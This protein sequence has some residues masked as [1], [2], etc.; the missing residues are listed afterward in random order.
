M[1]TTRWTTLLS[2]LVVAIPM[3]AGAAPQSI[4]TSVA[5]VNLLEL[6]T[7]EGCSSCPPADAWLSGLMNDQRLW[8]QI[9]PVAF[10]VDYWDNLGWHDPFD[11]HLYSERQQHIA[12]RAGDGVIYTPEFVLDGKPWSNWFNLRSLRLHDATAGGRLKLVVDGGRL[13]ASFTPV[14]TDQKYLELHVAILAFGVNTK[15]SAGENAGRTLL[16]DFLVIGY[17]KQLL[18]KG[19]SGFSSVAQLPHSI[20]VQASRYALA[21]WI[22]QP[23]DPA[24]LQSAGGWLNKA[25]P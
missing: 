24:P 20:K 10:H 9:V 19:I 23:G 3:M 11:K 14:N 5:R 21:V 16:Q 22:S 13:T 8:K 18:T 15:V 12:D 17:A 2:T 4:E 25:L 6:Y 1:K 7:S